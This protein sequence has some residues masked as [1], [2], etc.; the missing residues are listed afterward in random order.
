MTMSKLCVSTM[1]VLA[2]LAAMAYDVELTKSD[3]GSGS[4]FD[5]GANWNDDGNPPSSGKTYHVGTGMTLNT[6]S[7]TF[8]GKLLAVDGT[9]NS[10]SATGDTVTW[11]D[12]LLLD[13]SSYNWL[14]GT[15]SAL[16]GQVTVEGS[17]LFT[18]PNGRT[19]GRPWLNAKFVSGADGDL[20]LGHASAVTA[21]S[22]WHLKGDWTEY[23]GTLRVG[24]G[25]TLVPTTN[26]FTLGG[27]L[28]VETGGE[29]YNNNQNWGVTKVG[30][31]ELADGSTLKMRM[32]GTNGI[33]PVEIANSLSIGEDV[34]LTYM[35]NR[36]QGGYTV[37]QTDKRLAV[38]K[39]SAEAAAKPYDLSGVSVPDL[40]ADLRIGPFPRL[41]HL[42]DAA[43]ATTGGKTVYAKYEDDTSKLYRM[44]TEN[45]SAQA[46]TSAFLP[47]NASYWDFAGQPT[48]DSVGDLYAA[49]ALLF[50]SDNATSYSFLGLECTIAP[51]CSIYFQT[52]SVLFRRW[53]L[54]P[55]SGVSAYTGTQ[56]KDFNGP[57]TTYGYADS[58][59][60]TFTAFAYVTLNVND[61]VSG[62]GDLKFTCMAGR[63]QSGLGSFGLYG[64]NRE[65]VGNLSFVAPTSTN[66]WNTEKQQWDDVQF[67][68]LDTS[69]HLTVAVT[70]GNAF[71]GS[72]AG[73]TAW[74][75]LHVNCYSQID[76]KDSAVFNEPTRGMFVEWGG[77]VNVAEN[78]SFEI[79]VP[80]TL[81]GELI[82]KGK[83]ALVLSGTSRFIDGNPATEPVA[84]TNVLTVS[85]GKLKVA[86]V[87]AVNGMA[88]TLAK[89]T[90]L[91]LDAYPTEVGMA[92]TGFVATRWV[93]PLTTLEDDG[94]IPVELDLPA[95]KTTLDGEM[96]L[97][98]CTVTA[99]A[100]KTLKFRLPKYPTYHRT[101]T[102]RTNPDGSVTFLGVFEHRGLA[103]IVR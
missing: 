91:V 95:G 39:V 78:K 98:I 44:K 97:P 57:V 63:G 72:Y 23:L 94:V 76:V 4:S 88:I 100:A 40:A 101:V 92:E 64:D 34:S 80:L 16:A 20:T 55:G 1:T 6:R 3:T 46:A 28:V 74:R 69:R 83:G 21:C 67:P 36:P 30:A 2:G 17:V 49:K 27:K 103:I 61:A 99:D 38:F 93:T 52:G 47:G 31:L 42:V 22:E 81:A 25:V 45:G 68:K 73:T 86:S 5:N 24:S 9:I 26:P 75:S 58:K 10:I 82:K 89:G 84:G 7:G 14:N 54:T 48:P 15:A 41:R 50:H 33:Q 71:G 8:A 70:N 85:A 60:I 11:P 90:R 102:Q 13:G 77:Q 87:Q 59:P 56:V 66:T 79:G 96:T 19:D 35:N 37:G 51:S 32:F 12:L 65:F 62:N 18:G 29:L 53:H 43:D